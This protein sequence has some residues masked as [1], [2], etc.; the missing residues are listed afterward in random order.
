[1]LISKINIKG[2][3]SLKS[4]PM[5]IRKGAVNESNRNDKW[6]TNRVLLFFYLSSEG[7]FKKPASHNFIA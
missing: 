4:E 6:Y 5:T 2:K 7:I 1:M 3:F